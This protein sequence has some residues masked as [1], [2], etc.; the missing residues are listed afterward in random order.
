MM[1]RSEMVTF[2]SSN[3]DRAAE[4]RGQ[5][6][7]LTRYV[8]A[9]AGRCLLLWRGKPLVHR[10]V[11]NALAFVPLNDRVLQA[12]GGP[13]ILLGWEDE[14]DNLIFAS[15]ISG[16]IPEDLDDSALNS[17]ADDTQQCH[18]GLPDDTV[19]AELRQAMAGLSMRDAELSATAKAVMSWHDSHQFCARCGVQSRMAMAGWQR[20]CGACGVQHFPRTDPVVIMLIT[21]GNKVLVGRSHGWPEGIYSL[22][23]GF[24]EPGET[25]E[26]AVRRE[27]WE[28]SG[29]KLGAVTYL[30]SQPWPFPMSLMIGC[31]GRALNDEIR[32]DPTELDDAMWMTREEALQVYAGEHATLRPARKGSI[33]HFLMR[34]WLAD[35]L[36]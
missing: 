35:T 33:A 1:K 24:V 28:E 16:W 27:V 30:T 5:E 6:A 22:L 2:G 3:L 34:N 10:S 15:D 19:F 8:E 20:S 18:P 31:H 7:E 17:F 9:G 36:N 29:I 13:L 25:I 11:P 23:A 14:G 26:A 12:E 32:I 4:L 21:S